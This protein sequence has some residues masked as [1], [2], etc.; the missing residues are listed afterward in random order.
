MNQDYKGIFPA[1]VPNDAPESRFVGQ[2]YLNPLC[3]EGVFVCD[4]TFEPGS[5]NSWHIHHKGGQLLLCTAGHGFY[6]AWGEP[7]QALKAGDVVKIPPEV[8]H[9]HGA[10]PDSWFEHV[11]IAIPAEGAETEWLEPVEPQDYESMR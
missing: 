8:K 2:S 3:T 5:R 10:A 4:V 11:A 7:A 1:G 9:W 6:Q